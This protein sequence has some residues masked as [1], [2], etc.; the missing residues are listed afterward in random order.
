MA[1]PAAL[2]AALATVAGLA[3]LA[4]QPTRPAPALVE[5]PLPDYSDYAALALAAPVVADAMIRSVAAVKGAQAVGLAPGQARFYVTA[6]VAALLQGP[7]GLPARL[8]WLVDVPL[9]ARG[10]APRLN[11]QR[12]LIFART[13]A[14]RPAML[15]LITPDAQRGWTPAA[16][17]R[18]R[19]I[20]REAVAADAPP[21]VTGVGNAFFVPGSLPG[22]GETQVFLQT[23]GARPVSLS[24]IRDA[25]GNRRWSVALSEVVDAATPPPPRDTL[26]WYR[27]ACA[28]PATLPPASAVDD[29][30]ANAAAAREDYAYVIAALGPCAVR[31]RP[32]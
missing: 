27:L 9:D 5:Q 26:L 14:D 24:V 6:D 15:Q 23:A 32:I 21:V 25:A 12:V 22:E 13:L 31:I 18:T 7:A 2:A 16:D 17:A 10:K 4:A 19:G 30:P 8:S 3:P 28:L 1:L 29:E 11:K 20:L